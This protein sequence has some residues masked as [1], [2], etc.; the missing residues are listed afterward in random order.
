M[1]VLK[2][3]VVSDDIENYSFISFWVIRVSRA[4]FSCSGGMRLL[5]GVTFIL[6]PTDFEEDTKHRFSGDIFYGQYD[7]KRRVSSAKRFKFVVFGGVLVA[8]REATYFKEATLE[9]V[10]RPPGAET[11]YNLKPF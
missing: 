3:R 6:T 5:N 4:L 8:E 2:A 10:F 1:S 7:A 11:V 9:F